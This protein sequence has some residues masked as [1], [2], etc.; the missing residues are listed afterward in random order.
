MHQQM[1]AQFML[2]YFNFVKTWNVSNVYIKSKKFQNFLTINTKV[3][4]ILFTQ[5][6]LE[7]VTPCKSKFNQSIRFYY[8]RL[9]SAGTHIHK[10]V[11]CYS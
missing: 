2:F 5:L 8:G 1:Q 10:K 7:Q 6:F 11:Y 4:H 3:G 9:I